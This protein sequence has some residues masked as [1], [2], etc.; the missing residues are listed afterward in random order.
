MPKLKSG[1]KLKSAFK[2]K[3]TKTREQRMKDL[4]RVNRTRIARAKSSKS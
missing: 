1:F 2:L 3:K 4:R